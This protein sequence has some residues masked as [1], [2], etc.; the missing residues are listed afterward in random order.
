MFDFGIRR[1]VQ[2]WDGCW[3]VEFWCPEYRG[4][5]YAGV[6]FFPSACPYRTRMHGCS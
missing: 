2:M 5:Y 4:R 1:A 3:Q 6:I